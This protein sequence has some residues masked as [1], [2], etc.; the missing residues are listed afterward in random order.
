MNTNAID[1]MR[2]ALEEIHINIHGQV[3]VRYEGGRTENVTDK[4]GVKLYSKQHKSK[5]TITPTGME[6]K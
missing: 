3:I 4:R 1:T 5:D 6:R 2:E